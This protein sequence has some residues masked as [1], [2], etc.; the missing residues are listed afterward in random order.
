[1]S[2]A[3]RQRANQSFRHAVR[4]A[5][6]LRWQVLKTTLMP[7]AP[8][9]RPSA[10][11][12]AEARPFLARRND[13]LAADLFGV[14]NLHARS[15]SPSRFPL[16]KL[17]VRLPEL[18]GKSAAEY[19][20]DPIYFFRCAW[21]EC[22]QE[23]AT[24]TEIGTIVRRRRTP[25]FCS[26]LSPAAGTKKLVASFLFPKRRGKLM[27]AMELCYTKLPLRYGAGE[28]PALGFRHL[29]TG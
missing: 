20:A 10:A 2:A 16:H 8:A 27:G 11:I 22:R 14:Q 1:M 5:A 9:G 17:E 4:S 19:E 29:N 25:L 21:V 15:R 18:P 7:A 23:S 24:E 28:L 3:G 6:A 13:P 12:G 26:H